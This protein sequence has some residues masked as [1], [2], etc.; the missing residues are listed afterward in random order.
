MWMSLI[1]YWYYTGDAQ[2]NN[3]TSQA[4]QFQVGD[5]YDFMTVNQTKDEGNDDQSF[6]GFA[7]MTAAE[8]GFPNPPS[9][10]PS[11]LSLAQGVFNDQAARWDTTSC[12]GGLKWQIYPFNTGYNYKNGISNGCFFN[13]AS[14]LY[15]YTGN[16]TYADWAVK[17]YD[18]VEEIGIVSD[19]Y[20]VW[21]GTDDTENCTSMNH[22]Q[23][24]YNAGVF[25]YGAAMMWN[26]VRLFPPSSLN[27][28]STNQ[29]P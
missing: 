20:Q 27:L 5:D 6:W 14:R 7:A 11:W 9:G 17:M 22:Q 3:I 21:D 2:Y 13:L 15:R 23:W 1:D 19:Q 29:F 12:A 4:I 26:K 18:W 10:Q 28:T 24:T 25:L 8:L 16:Q